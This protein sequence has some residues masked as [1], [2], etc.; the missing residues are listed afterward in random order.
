MEYLNQTLYHMAGEHDPLINSN[1]QTKGCT[2]LDGNQLLL[3][4]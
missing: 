3:Y 4:L 2:I 1:L